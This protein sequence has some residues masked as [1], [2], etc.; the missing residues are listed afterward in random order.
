MHKQ[1]S[2]LKTDPAPTSNLKSI[3]AKRSALWQR[4][5]KPLYEKPTLKA[6]LGLSR[7]YCKQK[8]SEGNFQQLASGNTTQRNAQSPVI[9][10]YLGF[11]GLGGGDMRG[12]FELPNPIERPI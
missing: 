9:L 10:S 4:F 8:L 12:L 3:A 7:P 1:S 5:L 11:F 6:L 2:L